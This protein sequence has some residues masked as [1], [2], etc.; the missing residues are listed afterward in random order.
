MY[1]SN[2]DY[3]VHVHSPEDSDDGDEKKTMTGLEIGIIVGTIIAFALIL[4]FIFYCRHLESRR[5]AQRAQQ[6]LERGQE[7]RSEIEESERATATHVEEVPKENASGRFW[8][9]IRGL[10]KAYL[11]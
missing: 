1:P 8:S 6:Q 10:G 9:K 2:E 5:R 11:S 4:Y 3:Q 7:R